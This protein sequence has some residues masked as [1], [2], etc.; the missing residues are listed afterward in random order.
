MEFTGER[1]IP[2][3]GDVDLF[4]E[5]RAR[6]LFARN[7]SSGKMVLDAACGVGYGSALLAENARLVFGVDLAREAIEY[8][9]QSFGSPKVHFAQSDCLVLPFRSGQFE[10]VV[11]FEIIEHLDA[12]PFL[13][14][15]RR[16]LHP[17]GLLILST[18]NRLY[19]T[20]DRGEINP[21]HRRE[22][23]YPEFEEILQP[24]FPYRAILF[25]NHVAGL[26]VS[27]PDAEPNFT[28][29]SAGRVLQEEKTT[30]NVEE[31]RRAAHYFVA[32]CSAQPQ[33]LREPIPPLLYLPSTGNVLREREIHIHRLMDQLARL[34]DQTTKDRAEIE[35]LNRHLEERTI[36]ARELSQKLSEKE[37]YVLQL[38]QDYDSKVQW[39]L[40][41]EQD[42]EQA[43]AA[44]QALQADYDN[45]VQWAL[46]L[47]QDVEKARAALQK[48]QQEFEERTAWALKLAAEL[49][50]RCEDLRLLYDS[51]WYRIGK[52]LKLSPVPSS[53]QTLSDRGQR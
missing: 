40:G 33:E 41:L 30:P 43:R 31:K 34:M 8:A 22:F 37:A 2:G 39:A 44:L 4:N 24:L 27:G 28:A 7:F 10:L 29:P 42:L 38:Q 25:E 53:D 1:V 47:E 9:R 48:L 18:P 32:L 11:A 51:P 13:A 5:H 16:V 23:S 46:S 17:S 12:E 21:F 50:E 15:L 6:Y 19:Y 45:K 49:K 20:E 3:Q 35:R 36:W 14:E 26:M 52:N